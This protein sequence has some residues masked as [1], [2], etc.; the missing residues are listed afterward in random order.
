VTALGA[1][2]VL[3]PPAAALLLLAAGCCTP[4]TTAVTLDE[5]LAEHNANAAA[6]PRLWAR[7]RV[8]VDLVADGLPLSWGSTSPLAEPNGL[9]LLA[10]GEHRLGP[11]DFVLIGRETMA[12]ELFRLGSS[13]A[14]GR[15]YFWA[16]FGRHGG[17]WWGRHRYAG[18]PQ[19]GGLPIDPTQLLAVLGVC[20]LPDDLTELPAATLRMDRRP[21]EYAY[22]VSVLDRQPVSRRIVVQR[23]V[24]FTWDDRKPRRPFLVR[25]FDA[26][27]RPALTA[28][29]SDYR[30]I[31]SP[32]TAGAAPVMPADIR[33]SWEGPPADTY[34]RQ[35]HLVL[36][37]MTTADTWD[38]DACRFDPQGI[39]P[40]RVVQVD[41]HLDSG[42]DAP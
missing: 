9:L 7:A 25:I 19:V 3:L 33:I 26:A 30:P 20:E 27:G 10:K 21:C 22:V 23:E 4:P 41:A 40:G 11:H 17:A 8:Q 37:E 5:L 12:V 39:D 1:R 29:M 24:H 28:R 34:V 14:E 6:V 15:Y 36:S 2:R 38:R 31:D 16:R 32:D 13:V 18:A 35:I 42:D